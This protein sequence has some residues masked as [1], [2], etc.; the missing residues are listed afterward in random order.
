[1]IHPTAIIHPRAEIGS[2]CQIGA[3]CVIGEHVV[4]GPGCRLHSH[5]VVDG[6]TRLGEGNQV[7][8]F[9]TLGLQTQDLKW[10]GGITHLEI[11][12]FNTIRETVTIHT[13]TGDGEATVIGSNNAILA[14]SHIGHNVVMGNG[15]IEFRKKRRRLSG[16]LTKSC[17]VKGSP[18]RTP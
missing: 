12:N 10:K 8:P 13:A 9:T 11:G 4:L 18:F 1:M 16:R 3:Y 17:F 2:D 15:I 14:G 6:Y 5:V 7:Y